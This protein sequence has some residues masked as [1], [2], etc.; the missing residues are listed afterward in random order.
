MSI[1]FLMMILTGGIQTVMGPLV[2]A[3]VFHSV[4]DFFMPLTDFWRFFLGA[5]I[6]AIV[7]VFPRG[8]VGA[9]DTLREKLARRPAGDA[10]AAALTKEAA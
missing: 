4:K 3:A 10:T 9:I 6:I 8:V 5:S 2:G 7:L 1:D